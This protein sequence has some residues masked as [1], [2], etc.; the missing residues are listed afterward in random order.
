MTVLIIGPT[1][2][3][4]KLLIELFINLGYCIV[5]APDFKFALITFDKLNCPLIIIDE[6][7]IKTDNILYYIE[8]RKLFEKTNTQIIFIRNFITTSKEAFYFFGSS[9]K[10]IS[11]FFKPVPTKKLYQKAKN[12]IK[13]PIKANA[14]PILVKANELRIHNLIFFLNKRSLLKGKKEIKLTA[15]EFKILILLIYNAG[16]TVSRLKILTDVWGYIPERVNDRRIVDSYISKLRAKIEPNPF[17]PKYILT[18]RNKGYIF[19]KSL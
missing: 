11:Y 4:Q 10:S 15:I 12:V 6:H 18:E 7:Y 17:K 19:Q 3:L 2:Q 1:L 8:C 13:N 16:T 14:N 5:I 9:Y